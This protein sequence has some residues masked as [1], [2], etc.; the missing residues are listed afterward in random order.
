MHNATPEEQTAERVGV[1][2]TVVKNLATVGA[3]GALKMAAPPAPAQVA[4]ARQIRSIGTTFQ[5]DAQ[6]KG[7]AIARSRMA[8]RVTREMLRSLKPS[9][10]E[11]IH[12]K[13]KDFVS[14]TLHE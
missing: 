6:L 3:C 5:S 8:R 4:A 1:N 7:L 12:W 2:N 10:L 9:P 11:K 14:Q 13:Q